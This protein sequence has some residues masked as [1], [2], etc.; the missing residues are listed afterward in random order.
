MKKALFSL[1]SLCFPFI[2]YAMPLFNMDYAVYRA[3]DYSLLQIYAL[4]QRNSLIHKQNDTSFVAEYSISVEIKRSDS[5]LTGVTYDRSDRVA[6][7]EEI[8]TTQKI[9][10]E[11]SFHIKPGTYAVTTVITDLVNKDSRTRQTEVVIQDFPENKLALSD[12]E[13][14]S[15]VER[16]K[17]SGRFVKNRLLVI[18]HADGMFGGDL[19]TAY[20]YLEIYNLNLDNPN[21]EYSIRRTILDENKEPIKD[22]PEKSKPQNA[23]SVTE[24]DLFSCATLSTGSYY[25]RIQV[26]D[27]CSGQ[28]SIKEK[29]F[30]IYRPGEEIMPQQP[31][32]TGQLEDAIKQMTSEQAEKEIDYLR[33]LTDRTENNAIRDLQPFGYSNFLL[34]FWR[35]RDS[36]GGLRFRYLARI[37]AANQRYTSPFTEGWKTDRGRTLI[38]FGE[39]DMIERRNFQLGGQDAE[40]WYYDRIEG[41]VLFLFYDQKGTGDLQQVYSTKRGEYVDAGWVRDMEERD[42]NALQDLRNH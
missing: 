36:S 6:S 12:I 7:L 22:L 18:P 38:V 14:A 23:S 17:E 30:W 16:V 26:T 10:D 42:P 2:L 28:K 41:G 35:N 13:L 25:L 27:G 39:P 32:I 15:R 31:L 20:Y 1:L 4:I 40:V 11:V 34:N 3:K 37:E 33:Y 8:T 29:R 5:T 9:P 19:N 24:A 21:C